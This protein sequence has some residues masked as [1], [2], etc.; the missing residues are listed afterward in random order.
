MNTNTY[1]IMR[2]HDKIKSKVYH[3]ISTINA[4]FVTLSQNQRKGEGNINMGFRI[5]VPLG[6]QI[7]CICHLLKKNMENTIKYIDFI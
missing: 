3:G 2:K 1:Q 5:K 4:I 7:F 6:D